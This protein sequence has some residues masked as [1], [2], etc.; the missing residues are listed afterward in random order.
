MDG[1]ARPRSMVLS[2]LAVCSV[3]E[4][5]LYPPEQCPLTEPCIT[6]QILFCHIFALET[7]L[8]V[9][10]ELALAS[11]LILDLCYLMRQFGAHVEFH[12]NEAV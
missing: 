9:G 1:N 6:L 3:V 2:L 8:S 10:L 7:P 5:G 11:Y 12:W 4:F